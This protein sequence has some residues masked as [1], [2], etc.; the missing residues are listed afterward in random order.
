M[1][2]LL[3]II[4]PTYWITHQ[5]PVPEF[6]QITLSIFFG[7]LVVLGIIC[8]FLSFR[9]AQRKPY[10]RLFGKL[11]SWGWTMGLLGYALLFFSVQKIAYLSA[12]FF[13]LLWLATAIWWLYYIIRYAI[14]DIPRIVEKQKQFE[15]SEKYLPKRKK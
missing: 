11:S 15:A 4:K 10:R 7:L 14:K 12:R 3:A 5:H 9:K 13:Y 1:D 2:F 8:L 6:W